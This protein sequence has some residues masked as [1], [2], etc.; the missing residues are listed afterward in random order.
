[1]IESNQTKINIKMK[2]KVFSI[3]AFLV[4]PLFFMVS[5]NKDEEDKPMTKAEVIQV[6]NQATTE[7]A[8][9]MNQMMETQ[10]MQS[11]MQFMS[12][13]GDMMPKTLGYSIVELIP[14]TLNVL[15]KKKTED[16]LRVLKYSS[17]KS[18]EYGY[19]TYTWNN[20]SYSWDYSPE[21]TDKII[22]LFP[23]DYSQINNN[24]ELVIFNI[25]EQAVGDE[26]VLTGVDVE[27]FV[28]GIKVFYFYYSTTVNANNP[29]SIS[30]SVG[31]SPFTF[32]SNTSFEQITEGW[33]I[34]EVFDMKKD[35]V[36]LMTSDIE[37]TLKGEGSLFPDINWE[38]EEE[39]EFN[40]EPATV[41]GFFQMGQI[42]ITLNLNIEAFV[43]AG[44]TVD[45]A[46]LYLKIQLLTYPGGV[47]LGDIKWV[48]NSTYG[49]IE[50]YIV[51][52]DGSEMPLRDL[53]PEDFDF[54]I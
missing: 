19:G 25:Q 2:R 21:P 32:T 12:L 44:E 24:A 30:I 51:F 23:A 53:F 11:L 43:N 4:M 42:K 27:L 1:M 54:E 13:S 33:K 28:D 10:G 40:L 9:T 41:V 15:E 22:F 47:K 14:Q 45:A 39:F 26:L 7:M 38:D 49:D 16:Y 50:P 35:N 52:P 48:Y 6:L 31:M 18:D 17:I 29:E 5:C 20:S 3:L 37:I 46:N 36:V 8:L 34:R